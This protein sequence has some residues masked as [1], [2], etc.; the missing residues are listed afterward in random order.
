MWGQTQAPTQSHWHVM[1]VKKGG[2]EIQVKGKGIKRSQA[3]Q[4][5]TKC[6]AN[7]IVSGV[8]ACQFVDDVVVDVLVAVVVLVI[9]VAAVVAVVAI[10][11]APA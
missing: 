1:V 10:A 6:T 5:K 3:N 11:W 2:N 8:L 9:V 7:D 4:E